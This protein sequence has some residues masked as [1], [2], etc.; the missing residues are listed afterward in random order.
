MSSIL[1]LE[2]V[3]E[4]EVSGLVLHIIGLSRQSWSCYFKTSSLN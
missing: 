1:S 4:L 2:C 3:K